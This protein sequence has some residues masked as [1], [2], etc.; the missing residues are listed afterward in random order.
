[1]GREYSVLSTGVETRDRLLERRPSR[2]SDSVDQEAAPRRLDLGNVPT[3]HSWS[4]KLLRVLWFVVYWVL[5]RP[6]PRPCHR[7]RAFLLRLFGTRGRGFAVHRTARVWAPWNLSVGKLAIIDN[8]VD[9]Y[10]V[11]PVRIGNRSIVSRKTF[12]C[13]ATHDYECPQ[14]PL[15]PGGIDIGDDCWVCADVFVGPNVHVGDGTVVGARSVVIGDLPSWCVCA[16]HP[17]KVLKERV[18]RGGR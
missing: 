12:L 1:V 18:L 8:E 15:V 10:N 4:N 17:C 3:P 11:A 2:V 7:W 13:A 9:I 6:S 5:F 14:M 16:G